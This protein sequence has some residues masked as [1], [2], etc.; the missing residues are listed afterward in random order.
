[1]SDAIRWEER[2]Q[3]GDT[4]WDTGS[5]SSE[6]QRVLKEQGIEPCR[7]LELGC[8]TGT[9]C[10]YLAQQ[11]FEVTGID[12]SP[13]AVEKARKRAASAGVTVQFMQGSVLDTLQL[14]GPFA[15][16]FDRGCYHAV[17]RIDPSAY[18][19]TLRRATGPGAR[20]LVLAGN[21]KEPPTGPPVVTEEE[22]RGEL[23]SAFEILQLREFRFDPMPGTDVCFLGWSCWLRKPG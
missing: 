15:F 6:L 14:T 12:L 18:V 3:T 21:A 9:N 2:Y 23:G 19:A 10:V 22:I 4:P 20:G 13:L 16:F 5:P 7:A 17:R 11:G 1:M 8:G